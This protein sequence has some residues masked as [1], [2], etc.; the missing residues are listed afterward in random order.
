[1]ETNFFASVANHNLERFHSECLKWLFNTNPDYAQKVICEYAH[2]KN[3]TFLFAETE[4]EQL[5]LV[6]CYRDEKDTYKALIIENKVKAAESSKTISTDDFTEKWKPFIREELKELFTEPGD[7]QLSQTEYYY[8]RPEAKKRFSQVFIDKGSS[9]T[10]IC[11]A[12]HPVHKEYI[13]ISKHNYSCHF[14]FLLPTYITQAD[15]QKI[16]LS[17]L[18]LPVQRNN[19]RSWTAAPLRKNPWTMI[20]YNEL[21]SVFSNKEAIRDQ[22]LAAEKQ[23]FPVAASI[24]NSY[25]DFLFNQAEKWKTE[26]LSQFDQFN[27]EKYGAAEYFRVLAALVTNQQKKHKVAIDVSSGSSKN[28]SP[29]MDIRITSFPVGGIRDCGFELQLIKKNGNKVFADKLSIGIQVQGDVFKIFM[30]AATDYDTTTINQ[31]GKAN[32]EKYFRDLLTQHGILVKE[33]TQFPVYRINGT[34]CRLS[35]N[36]PDG[37]TFLS[38]SFDITGLKKLTLNKRGKVCTTAYSVATDIVSRAD[39][40]NY[41]IDEL[42]KG[43]TP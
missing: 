30:S 11:I 29:L 17:N 1:M 12:D 42:R 36:K 39:L 35:I 20:T 43:F 25:L 3:I 4:V 40:I 21:I 33:Y 38:Y 26:L 15:L 16:K 27:P 31:G 41:L 7:N 22:L 5:D 34:P 10:G 23:V 9:F 2:Q 28:P 8:I 14:L 24:G 32:Y 6:L 13:N 37:K 19:W 18:H